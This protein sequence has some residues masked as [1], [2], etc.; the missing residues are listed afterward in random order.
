[1]RILVDG[2]VCLY[3]AGFS[4]Q[5]KDKDAPVSHSVQTLNTLLD[6]IKE[7][8][9]NQLINCDEL[10]ICLSPI[11]SKDNFRYDVAKTKPYK[12]NRKDSPKPI[13]FNEMKDYLIDRYKCI[14][15]KGQEADDEMGILA[16]EDPDN[17][18][19][20]SSDKDMRMVPGWHWELSV[21]RP[22]YFVDKDKPGYLELIREP[23]KTPKLF[24][25]GIAWFCAQCLMGDRA[26]NIPGLDKVG[27][28]GAYNI[29]KDCKTIAD[30]ENKVIEEYK[31]RGLLERLPEI[32]ELLWIRQKRADDGQEKEE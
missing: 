26:D 10:I 23:G 20:V 25:T 27:V 11:D 19:I 5:S 3:K 7:Y 28:V 8:L 4:A 1:M 15:T 17:T 6:F 9:G 30:Y 32:Q 29:L 31:S 2:D 14:T 22:P 13:N 16:Q 18:I 12:E 24:G 21:D